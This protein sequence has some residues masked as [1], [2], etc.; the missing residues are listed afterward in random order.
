MLRIDLI[1]RCGYLAAIFESEWVVSSG[2]CTPLLFDQRLDLLDLDLVI[3]RN[4]AFFELIH[5]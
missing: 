5:Q 4:D 3:L 2:I 1:T